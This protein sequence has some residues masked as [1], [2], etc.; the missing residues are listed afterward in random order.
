MY[1]YLRI[2]CK[3][4]H[5]MFIIHTTTPSRLVQPATTGT[6]FKLFFFDHSSKQDGLAP[7]FSVTSLTELE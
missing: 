4:F 6:L 3:V 1:K 7:A 5:A 2:W